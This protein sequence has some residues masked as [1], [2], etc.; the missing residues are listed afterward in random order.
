MLPRHTDMA[1]RTKYRVEKDKE[2]RIQPRAD[3]DASA[4]GDSGQGDEHQV[5]EKDMDAGQG[6][7]KEDQTRA[8]ADSLEAVEMASM[9]IDGHD[10]QDSGVSSM[11]TWGSSNAEPEEDD[12]GNPAHDPTIE[13]KE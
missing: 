2:A 6:H 13:D 10:N 7:G 4:A 3:V 12:G 11:A 5:F 1:C 9:G 8:N